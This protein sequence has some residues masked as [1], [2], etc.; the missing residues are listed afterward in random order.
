MDFYID[1][2]KIIEYVFSYN[3]GFRVWHIKSGPK[4]SVVG[5]IVFFY[6]L[7]YMYKH[8]NKIRTWKKSKRLDEEIKIAIKLF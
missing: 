6:G 4:E 8:D 1:D 3:D 2:Y 5:R 7:F